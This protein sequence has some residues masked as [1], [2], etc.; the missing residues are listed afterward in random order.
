[1]RDELEVGLLCST[2]CY[3]DPAKGVWLIKTTRGWSLKSKSI[4]KCETQLLNQL[5]LKID[6]TKAH[7]Y[8]Y[9][10]RQAFGLDE[11]EGTSLLQNFRRELR[12]SCCLC[13]TLKDL[14]F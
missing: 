10:L 4:K 13:D 6:E 1:M 3:L 2:V 9:P 8:T 14:R 12:W 7:I 5:A 11:E